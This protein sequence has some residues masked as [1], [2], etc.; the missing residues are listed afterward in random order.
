[1]SKEL[2]NKLPE[3]EMMEENHLLNTVKFYTQDFSKDLKEIWEKRKI[4][5]KKELIKRWIKEFYENGIKTSIIPV[6]DLSLEN[7]SK[8]L[9]NK[10][11]KNKSGK[12]EEFNILDEK[13]ILEFVLGS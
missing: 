1:M 10:K 4:E 6:D 13:N 7:L 3:P 8:K 2:L 11:T 5:C 12:N 9:S